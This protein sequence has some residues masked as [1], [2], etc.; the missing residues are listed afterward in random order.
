MEI[1]LKG[2][3]QI[4]VSPW[5][6]VVSKIDLDDDTPSEVELAN[7][8]S[9]KV[10]ERMTVNVKVVKCSDEINIANDKKKTINHYWRYVCVV[11]LWEEN[12]VKLEFGKSYKLENFMVRE[13]A[14][15]KFLSMGREGYRIEA[16]A[17]IGD[18][19]APH[20]MKRAPF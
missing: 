5:T 16:I 8:H 9:L 6:F 17:N 14:S 15:N 4:K 13:Y 20:R 19:K 18:I 10:Y 7:V 3:T 12:M 1:M 11:T 2:T